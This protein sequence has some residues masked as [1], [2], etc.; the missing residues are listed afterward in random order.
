MPPDFWFLDLPIYQMTQWT[1]VKDFNKILPE[2]SKR[3][4]IWVSVQYYWE[5]EL[6]G[7]FFFFNVSKN[8]NKNVSISLKKFWSLHQK[9][10]NYK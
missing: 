6:V 3:L 2:N 8:T 1:Q 7:I 5:V 9:P 4:K 10:E